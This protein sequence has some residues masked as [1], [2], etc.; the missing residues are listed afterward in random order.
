[1]TTLY[2]IRHSKS[3]KACNIFNSDN[4]QIQNEKMILS[5]EGEEFANKSLDISELKGID[6]LIS[7]NYVRAISTAKYIANNNNIDVNIIELFGERIFGVNSWEEI[8]SDFY[9][10]QFLEPDY[11]IGTGE[12]QTEV[13][14]RMFKATK[15]VLSNHSNERVA[16]VTHASALL[17]LIM[18]WCDVNKNGIYY[19]GDFVAPVEIE[20]CAIFKMV[21]DEQSNL[22]SIDKI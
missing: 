3:Q 18:N 11:K 19:N 16:I 15:E 8:P 14:N 2:F 7:S 21:F 17:F 5:V 22:I 9:D 6:F 20:N 1:M 10:R 4:L 13:R 12:S